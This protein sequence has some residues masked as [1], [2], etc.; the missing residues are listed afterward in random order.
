MLFSGE[1]YTT[2][3]NLTLPPAVTAG[4]NI[5]SVCLGRSLSDNTFNNI[6]GCGCYG[7]YGSNKGRGSGRH[8]WIGGKV[9]HIAEEL[10]LFFLGDQF[11]LGNKYKRSL[12]QGML[13]AKISLQ[14]A[15]LVIQ[16][17]V[18]VFNKLIKDGCV[19]VWRSRS[20][21]PAVGRTFHQP[22]NYQIRFQRPTSPEFHF[23]YNSTLPK[24]KTISLVEGATL[25]TPKL[26]LL[27]LEK[28][29]AG[30]YFARDNGFPLWTSWT[31]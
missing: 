5:T 2:G 17:L 19:C 13:D 31:C 1:I 18:L 27:L 6:K 28:N 8:G 29:V 14:P 10:K 30:R 7:Y 11:F 25:H 9:N 21:V 20:R 22:T 12:N 4:T 3:K 15:K 23:I 16:L 26:K 24:L